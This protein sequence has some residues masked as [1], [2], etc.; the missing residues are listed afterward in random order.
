[1]MNFQKVL[2]KFILTS[3]LV[4]LNIVGTQ[5]VWADA[6]IDPLITEADSLYKLRQY[7]E[8]FRLY[9]QLFYEK[10]QASPAMLL[11]MAFIQESLD[12]YSEALYYLNEYYQATSDELAIEKMRELS[13]EHQLRGYEYTDY[14]L[15]YNLLRKYRY[16]IIFGIIAILLVSLAYT[17]FRKSEHQSRFNGLRLGMLVAIGLLFYVTNYSVGPSLAIIM[18]DYVPIMNGPSSGA[19]V[20]Y[21]TEKGHRVQVEG[22]DDVW[23]KIEWNGETAYIRQSN[24]RPI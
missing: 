17:A 15:F 24:L 18:N 5:I 8:S 6:P 21:I 11:K 1:M 12:E 16:F 19:D 14:D 4:C 23:A 9:E 10:Q 7:T 3:L 22:E 2:R 13:T 20:V